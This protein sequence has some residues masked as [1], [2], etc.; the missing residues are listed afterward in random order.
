[1]KILVFTTVFPNKLHPNLGVFV[2]QRISHLAQIC[3]VIVIA[4]VPWFPFAGLIKDKYKYYPAYLENQNGIEVYHPRFFLIPGFLKWLDGFF[5]FLSSFWTFKKLKREFHFDL[6]DA[7]FAYPD[8]FAAVLLGKAFNV[9]V[10]I[11]LRGTINRLIYFPF[12]KVLLKWA[13]KR[14]VKV[15]SVSRYLVDLAI[16]NGADLPEEKIRV[17]PNGVDLQKF[18]VLEKSSC[19]AKLDL[20]IG[21][22]VLISVGGLVERKGHHRV[23]Q[24]LPQML[25][26]FP[27]LYYVIVGGGGSEGD[28][29]PELRRLAEDLEVAHRV[30]FAGEVPHDKV[31][32]YLCAADVFVLPTRFEGWPNVFLEAMACGLPVVTTQVCGNAEV[33]ND[34]QTGLLVPFGEPEALRLALQKALSLDWDRDVIVHHARSR[35]WDQVAQEVHQ[36]F[37]EVLQERKHST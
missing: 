17:I 21:A 3:E 19:R 9:P 25:Q 1:M 31:K 15:I 36:A 10:S 14:A 18:T 20:P 13:L 32:Q 24:I 27:D 11:T 29:G 26:E 7:H 23:L 35:T 2:H 30:R 5:L 6:I 37:L 34:G 33:V 22:P 28:M 8:G 12:R 16:A 4:P